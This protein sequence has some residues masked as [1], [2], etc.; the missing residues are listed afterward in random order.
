[1]LRINKSISKKAAPYLHRSQ[2]N[3]YRVQNFF[4]QAMI[5]F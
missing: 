2:V 4:E 3:D 5:M 1:M